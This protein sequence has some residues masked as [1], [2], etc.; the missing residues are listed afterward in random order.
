MK[1]WKIVC[2]VL[3][4]L[5]FLFFVLPVGWLLG[6]YFFDSLH[7]K[8]IP[9][10]IYEER[11]NLDFPEPIQETYELLGERGFTGDGTQYSV[12]TVGN[13]NDAFFADFSDAPADEAF[14]S[15]FTNGLNELQVPE[16]QRPNLEKA[17][18]W[19]YFGKNQNPFLTDRY[20]D[21]LYLIWDSNANT[22][23]LLEVRI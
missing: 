14:L 3:A 20:F 2:I 15:G 1:K 22:L 13:E 17:Y 16:E 11:W 6:E 12:F 5:V 4:I 10:S 23:Y 9:E 21:N 8:A 7:H 19:K 18:Q